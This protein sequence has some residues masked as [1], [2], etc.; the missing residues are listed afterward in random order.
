M[1]SADNKISP[2]NIYVSINIFIF[3]NTQRFK[4]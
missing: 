3:I 1:Y 4:Q 2:Q